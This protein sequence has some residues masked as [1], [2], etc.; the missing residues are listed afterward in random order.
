MPGFSTRAVHA[1]QEPDRST[2]AVVVPIYQTSTFAQEAVGKHRG[3]EYSRTGNPTR[4]A[5]EQCIASLEGGAHGLAF[6]SGMAAEA[7]IMQLLKPN[8][9]TVAVD[10]LYGGTYRLFRRVLEP[11]GLSFSFVDGSDLQAV[12]RAL[13]DRTRMVWVESP[14]NPLLKLVDIEAVSK[15]A[16][17][18]KA[19]VV[20][21]NTFMSP[22]FQR[23]L[24]LGADIVVHSATKYL[25]GH[26][27]VIGGTL[28]VDREDL[29]EQLA[30]LQNALG[31]VPGPLD[32]WLVLRGLKTLA[33]RMREHDRNAR[34]VAAFLS[35]HPKVARVFYPGLPSNPQ[36]EL[37]RR[38]MSGF[39]GMISFE[40]KG[41]LEP[42][43]RVVERTQ[44]F[45]LAES[46]GGVES[47]I[48]LPAA[49]THSSI[50]TETRRAHGVA[51][52]LVRLSVGIEDVADL[53]SD[54]DRALAEA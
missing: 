23:P 26:S 54:L 43:R 49:M 29:L 44:L 31:G 15:L 36:R 35:E 5:L 20:V 9:H 34:L 42:A 13:T 12:E 27:D 39:G 11:M 48:E 28:V 40:V 53:I 50:P 18:N 10:D 22:Y 47:L 16:H 24:S 51:D 46:L 7:A 1:G 37:A 8:D 52:G 41:G 4:A 17:A 19:L 3:Y 38:Q 33:V 6:A 25:G 32:A 14:T 30:F 45:T 21:D 2:G